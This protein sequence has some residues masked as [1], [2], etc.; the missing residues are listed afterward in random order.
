[1]I[2]LDFR[3]TE[4]KSPYYDY[5]IEYYDTL[6][7]RLIGEVTRRLNNKESLKVFI[8]YI[9]SLLWDAGINQGCEKVRIVFYGN[10]FAMPKIARLKDF[11]V[12]TSTAIIPNKGQDSTS[13]YKKT[14]QQAISSIFD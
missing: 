5:T 13:A 4:M 3:G 11:E 9:A 7:N 6:D 8:N 10:N 12:N 1:M 14:M 2:L